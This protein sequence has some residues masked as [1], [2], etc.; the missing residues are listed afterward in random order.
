M[1]RQDRPPLFHPRQEVHRLAGSGAKDNGKSRPGN[2]ACEAQVNSLASQDETA[3]LASH[4]ATAA[5]MPFLEL[6]SLAKHTVVSLWSQDVRTQRRVARRLEMADA[7]WFCNLG[8]GT[9]F[10]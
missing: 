1:E 9:L 2:N 8:D 6:D 5:Y 7:T 4:Q 3:S 10:R